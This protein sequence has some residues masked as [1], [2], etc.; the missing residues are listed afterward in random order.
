MATNIPEKDKWIGDRGAV[1]AHLAM[2]QAVIARL[3]T[4]SASSKTWCLALVGAVTSLAGATR[5]PAILSYVGVAVLIFW[6]LDV[7][8]LAQEKAFRDLFDGL[9]AKVGR[10]DSYSLDD[11]YVIKAPTT[12]K[13]LTDALLSWSTSPM[14]VAILVAYGFAWWQGWVNLLAA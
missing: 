14:Y 10:L 12:G 2:I 8:Y 11:V 6:F 5:Q 1:Q 9:A 3:A 4:A 13:H 7:R